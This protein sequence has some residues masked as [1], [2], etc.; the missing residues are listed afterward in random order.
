MAGIL[1]RYPSF[2]SF[3]SITLIIGDLGLGVGLISGYEPIVNTLCVLSKF[4]GV[5]DTC[6]KLPCAIILL[7]VSEEESNK[8]TVMPLLR[9]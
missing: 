8:S 6:P 4:C 7:L 3:I 1:V 9:K 2:C 5:D